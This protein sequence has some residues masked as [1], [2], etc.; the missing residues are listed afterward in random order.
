VFNSTVLRSSSG[1]LVIEATNT[2]ADIWAPTSAGNLE[3]TP[4]GNAVTSAP[5][6]IAGATV[7][8][9]PIAGS[10]TYYPQSDFVN[11]LLNEPSAGNLIITGTTTEAY[12]YGR[13][14]AGNLTVSGNTEFDRAQAR[15]TSGNLIVEGNSSDNKT[16]TAVSSGN[17]IITNTGETVTSAP[18]TIAGSVLAE[19]PIAGS[20]SIAVERTQ[21]T[22]LQLA[23]SAGNLI[24]TGNSTVVSGS[25]SRRTSSGNLEITGTTAANPLYQR[26]SAGN[27]AITGATVSSAT[28]A[29]NSSGNLTITGTDNVQFISRDVTSAGELVV[30]GTSQVTFVPGGRATPTGGGGS[31]VF[32]SS[33]D[34]LKPYFPDDRHI[35]GYQQGQTDPGNLRVTG[36]SQVTVVSRPPAPRKT[37]GDYIRSLEPQHPP[38]RPA[39]NIAT[40]QVN[41]AQQAL[42]E[43]RLLLSGRLLDFDE[44]QDELEQELEQ[45]Y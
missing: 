18:S 42:A 8:E 7:A 11:I 5:S 26:V 14:T 13:V 39:P 21:I 44:I 20:Y 36:F 16:L 40:P 12:A 29:P 10:F 6:T 31:Y 28:W 38:S 22:V 37:L 9:S 41:F 34:I 27:L 33:W 17:L 15:S 24:I 35:L 2:F 25:V 19:S 4:I 45:S 32:P 23:D 1:N 43:D 30:S 3:I